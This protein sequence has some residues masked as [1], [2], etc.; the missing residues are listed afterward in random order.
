VLV[1]QDDVSSRRFGEPLPNLRNA[2][3]AEDTG[4]KAF[5]YGSE[6]IWGRVGAGPADDPESMNE[7]NWANVFSSRV[8][9]DSCSLLDNKKPLT[10]PK[11][12]ELDPATPVF[13]A[14]AGTPVRFRVVHPSGHPRNHAFTLSGHD[15]IMNPWQYDQGHHGSAVMGWNKESSTRFGSTSGIGPM[16][17]V[18]ILT[19]AGGCF[20]VPGDY[21]YRTQEGFM[22]GGGLWGIFRVTPEGKDSHTVPDTCLV[23]SSKDDD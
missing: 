18:N 22:F 14:E 1:Y 10:D 21:L 4:Q 19:T 23:T 5:N 20:K 2:D 9:N 8:G 12:C 3:D 15:W 11:H 7:Q 6:P 16:R 13:T 17:H